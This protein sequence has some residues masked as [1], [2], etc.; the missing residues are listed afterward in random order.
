MPIY[1]YKCSCG[2]AFDRILPLAR[3]AEPQTC[4]CGQVAAKVLVAPAVLADLPGYSCPITGKWVE[5]RRAHNE[6]LARHGCRVYEPGE[7]RQ[8]RQRAVQ[9]EEALLET[10]AETAAAYAANL[11]SDKR[12]RL[13]A[14]LENGA[15]VSVERLT[16]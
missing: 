5:G 13:G 2:R 3:Y 14:E 1:S 10:I 9:E 4:E 7:T 6:N 12:E 8:A 15:S 11:P 16:A